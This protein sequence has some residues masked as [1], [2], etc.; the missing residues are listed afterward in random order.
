MLAELRSRLQKLSHKALLRGPGLS[1]AERRSRRLEVTPTYVLATTLMTQID[2][3]RTS[4]PWGVWPTEWTKCGGHA[5]RNCALA[6]PSLKS[7]PT[8]VSPARLIRFHGLGT[9]SMSSGPPL[10]R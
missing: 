7:W 8:E 6:R 1:Y 5:A 9:R 2:G 3:R 4:G 10:R